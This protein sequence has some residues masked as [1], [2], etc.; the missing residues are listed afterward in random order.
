MRPPTPCPENSLAHH[1]WR[2]RRWVRFHQLRLL[3]S[4]R[5][6][7]GGKQGKAAARHLSTHAVCW[8]LEQKSRGVAARS[9][10]RWTRPDRLRGSWHSGSRGAVAQAKIWCAR[11]TN[12]VPVLV[13]VHVLGCVGAGAKWL[14][15]TGKWA[16][17]GKVCPSAAF[18]FFFFYFIF[19]LFLFPSFS[20]LDLKFEF[21]FV[22]FILRLNLNNQI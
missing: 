10:L 2:G 6:A 7:N 21:I 11:M 17:R 8:G 18:A 3:F 9:A 16:V 15:R 12:G 14:G 20:N 4:S 5:A 13:R 1:Q 19:F 22:E